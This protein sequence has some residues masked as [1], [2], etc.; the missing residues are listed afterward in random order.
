MRRP[1]ALIAGLFA[2]GLALAPAVADARVGQGSSWGSRGSRT[3]SQPPA[4]N[5]APY[6]AQPMQRSTVPNSPAP[7]PY[8]A[9]YAGGAAAGAN[10]MRPRSAFTSG[11]LGGLIG[12]GIGGMLLGHG[13]FGGFS[14][15]GSFFGFLIQVFL[16]VL[17]VRWLL[18]RFR[19][20]STAS[21]QPSFAGMS[22][23][24]NRT[25]QG[26]GGQ[27]PLSGMFGGGGAAGRPAPVQTAPVALT[28][29]DY[30]AFEQSLKGV[31]AAWT[32]GDLNALRGLATPEMVGYFAEQLADASSR[33][34]RNSVTEVQLIKG[35]LAEAW[36]E[37][38]R[39]YATV[40]MRFSMLDVTRDAGGRVVE[41]DP[42]RRSEATELW[43]FMRSNGGRWILSA[44][45]QT[46]R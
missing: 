44:I 26:G 11:L 6:S 23:M 29:A 21:A 16:I 32:A 8:A 31:Q 41:G 14:G 2:L 43:T 5:T 30:G 42:S 36:Q 12:A 9:P 40:A 15:I 10:A 46:G 24:L 39:E 33:G 22:N 20:G 18:R 17:V 28:P 35:D 19:G 13:F 7:A 34:V 3:W 1:T 38:G 4:T 37:G 45:Q 25:G 27:G